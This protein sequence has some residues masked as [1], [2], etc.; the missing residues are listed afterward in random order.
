MQGFDALNPPFDRLAHPEVE[1]LKAALDI[2]YFRPGEV[3][4]QEGRPS[5]FLH[6]IIKGAVEDR[7]GDMLQAVLGPKDT[8][9]SRAVVHGAAGEDFIAAEETLCHLIP[10][11]I[12]QTLIRRN[13]AFA[14]FF[15]SE[16]SRKLDAL[17]GH[18]RS[19]GV[20][21]VLRALVRD[22][23]RV[24]VVTGMNLSKAVVLQRLPLDTPIRNISHF[25][26]TAVGSDDF[27]FEALLLMTRHSRRRLAVRSD[28]DYVGFL[29]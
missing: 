1:E 7:A 19:E 25:D 5:D 23:D 22:G 29:E 11:P 9:D 16:V 8:F 6:V 12:I 28:G 18:Q 3:I 26:V 13:P 27:I 4:V 17:A 15:Y 20:E 14:A 21:T 24:G 2:G 10:Q